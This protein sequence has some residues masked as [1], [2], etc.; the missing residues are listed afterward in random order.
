MRLAWNDHVHLHQGNSG[1]L[2]DRLVR[3]R[4]VSWNM[5]MPKWRKKNRNIFHLASSLLEYLSSPS[6]GCLHR[7]HSIHV[8]R[9]CS[10]PSRKPHSYS[11]YL[12][13]NPGMDQGKGR[14]QALTEAPQWWLGVG[15]GPSSFPCIK[16]HMCMLATV[17]LLWLSLN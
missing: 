7:K 6:D 1:W 2:W 4:L 15:L 14:H 11:S 5:Y 13:R 16:E 8:G 12:S 10:T 9:W 17:A 3:K